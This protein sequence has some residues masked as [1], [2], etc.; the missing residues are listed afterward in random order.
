MRRLTTGIFAALSLIMVAD[1]ALQV[2]VLSPGP[3][4]EQL[5]RSPDDALQWVS[6]VDGFHEG[7]S[8][9]ITILEST[10]DRTL[11]MW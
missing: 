2:P 8:P 9:V 11:C 7:A 10:A 3:N 5:A 4:A 6:L 1:A